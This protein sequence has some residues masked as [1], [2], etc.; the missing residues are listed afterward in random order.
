M[1]QIVRQHSHP[2]REA[3]DEG[4]HP[5]RTRRPATAHGRR[6]GRPSPLS[7]LAVRPITH[8]RAV[9]QPELEADGD[10]ENSDN[11]RRHD[12]T[13]NGAEKVKGGYE[14]GHTECGE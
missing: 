14:A 3:A 6:S 13:K 7:P 12:G 8:P 2:Q 10:G 1:P 9:D 11:G 4:D 5:G